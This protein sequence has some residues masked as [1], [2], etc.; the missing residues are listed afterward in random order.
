MENSWRSCSIEGWGCKAGIASNRIA[1][2]LAAVVHGMPETA[3]AQLNERLMFQPSG[4]IVEHPVAPVAK[5]SAMTWTI[6]EYRGA[7]VKSATRLTLICAGGIRT[8]VQQEIERGAPF[9]L[10]PVLLA[11]GSFL[12]FSLSFEPGLWLTSGL[13]L[14]A[15]V[16]S[17]TFRRGQPLHLA[18]CAVLFFALGITCAQ[19]ETARLGTRIIGGE[20]STRIV[21]R[22]VSV[23]RLESGRARLTVDLI[24]T[25]RPRLK[26]APDRIRATARYLA[27]DINAGST[28]AGLVKLRPPSGP[29]RP[30]SYDF[31]FE[32]YFDGIGASGYF[33]RGPE[34]E[35]AST[36][37]RSWQSLFENARQNIAVHVR[38]RIGGAEGEIA[39]ALMVGVRAGIPHDVSEA[40]RRTGL[41]HIISIS[42]LHM[43][44]VAGVVIAAIR[45]G[46]A[47]FP[48]LALRWPAKK[49]SALAGFVA[50]AGYLA[51]SGGEVA[52]QRS[53]LM[54]AVMLI[55]VLFDRA[56][57]TMRNLAISAIIVLMISPHEVMGPSFQMSF[58]AT[59]ALVAAYAIWSARRARAS[60]K[61]RTKGQ[62]GLGLRS[63]RHFMTVLSSLI[64]TSVIAGFATAAYGVY[65][66]QRVAPLS[67][68]ANLFVMPIVSIVVMPSAVL[69]AVTM[70]L[71]LDGPFLDVM[72]KGIA[73]MDSVAEWFSD[74]S[75]IDAVGIIPGH[76]V[77][78]LTIALV[79][80]TV[81]STRL[82]LMSVPFAL[83]AVFT[84]GNAAT[85]D[86][87]VTE[88]GKL[89]GFRATDGALAVNRHQPNAF[90][91][92]NWKRAFEAER[93]R[94]PVLDRE[95]PP[96]DQP[97]K[98][99]YVASVV[100]TDGNPFETA[101]Q[102]DE[103]TCVGRLSSGGLIVHTS[104]V[105]EARIACVL[106]TVVILD[107]ATLQLSLRQSVDSRHHQARPRTVWQRRDLFA[108]C[109]Q[110]HCSSRPLRRCRHEPPVAP[111]S[112]FLA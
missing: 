41:Y 16:G 28:V 37:E 63:A 24:S 10:V 59:A 88:D 62:D 109:R 21:G 12:Y 100:Q 69:A 44:L 22:V 43:A 29:V 89:S 86:V 83:A 80:A 97:R 75:P 67:L 106:A 95:E 108:T 61:R 107:D 46:F 103:V 42:G 84:L 9:L 78:L 3:D 105:E 111:T 68:F 81:M 71:G 40:L 38:S 90:T 60:W 57:L 102:C 2:R 70:P 112:R 13:V 74:R 26:Y 6:A 1:S 65:H 31:S 49:F 33:M 77:V 39:A 15:S 101:F 48:R 4:D 50:I 104:D 91:A 52:A 20:I 53:F 87:L 14:V 66:F 30:E 36:G 25:E 93:F 27:E 11:A 34:L 51:I 19:L 35:P 17:R 79:I 64:A 73:L 32:S 85:P 23:E 55:A 8:A 96:D 56:A 7:A 82:R 45:A 58:A 92:E 72:G 110:Q 98:T 76:S 5:R 99:D 18:A 47:L 94:K 54:L